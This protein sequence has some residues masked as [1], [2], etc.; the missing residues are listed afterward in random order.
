MQLTKMSILRDITRGNRMK[1]LL[2][3]LAMGIGVCFSL[4]MPLML[5]GTIDA[6]VSAAEGNMTAPVDLPSALGSVV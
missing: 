4:I 3:I 2:S 1:F 5:S 6:L